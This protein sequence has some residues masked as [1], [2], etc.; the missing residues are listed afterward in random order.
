M[1]LPLLVKDAVNLCGIDFQLKNLKTLTSSI[2]YLLG[3]TGMLPA[4]K[5]YFVVVGELQSWLEAAGGFYSCG[6][7]DV[8]KM[9]SAVLLYTFKNDA[10]DIVNE[11]SIQV[12]IFSPTGSVLGKMLPETQGYTDPEDRHA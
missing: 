5:V 2:K 9:A 10:V 8:S 7:I 12:L 1:D 3:L 6:I 4:E 11:T